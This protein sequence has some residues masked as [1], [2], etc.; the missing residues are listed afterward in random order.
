[1]SPS[2]CRS[3]RRLNHPSAMS[4]TSASDTARTVGSAGKLIA[5]CSPLRPRAA[6]G[7]REAGRTIEVCWHHDGGRGR[8][9]FEATTVLSSGGAESAESF[10]S[11]EAALRYACRLGYGDQQLTAFGHSLMVGR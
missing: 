8:G 1:M 9:S 6:V 11:P 7:H 10:A 3:A 4:S 2:G 5:R